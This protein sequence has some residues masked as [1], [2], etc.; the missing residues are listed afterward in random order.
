MV[1]HG[2]GH[3]LKKIYAN[4]SFWDHRKYKDRMNFSL[5]CLKTSMNQ[6][7]YYGIPAFFPN[8][9]DILISIGTVEF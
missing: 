4:T 6:H 2:L 7:V 1:R 9:K 5:R 3:N 8:E